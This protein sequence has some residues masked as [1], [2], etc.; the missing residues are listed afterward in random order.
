VVGT[1][2]KPHQIKNGQAPAELT[3]IRLSGKLGSSSLLVLKPLTLRIMGVHLASLM[4][5][6]MVTAM[7]LS[8]FIQSPIWSNLRITMSSGSIGKQ[9]KCPMGTV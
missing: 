7:E 2:H 1:A 8:I 3:T 4:L 9:Y 5:T 6:L